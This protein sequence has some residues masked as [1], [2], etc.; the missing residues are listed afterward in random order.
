MTTGGNTRLLVYGAFLSFSI[1]AVYCNYVFVHTASV[2]EEW[3]GEYQ[4]LAIQN[5]R[6]ILDG[7]MPPPYGWRVLGDYLIWVVEQLTSID[8][9]IADQALRVL[10]LFVSCIYLFRFSLFYTSK[11]AAFC[12]V[13]IYLFLVVIGESYGYFIYN[14]NDMIFLCALH[15]CVYTL[16]VVHCYRVVGCVFL[17]TFARESTLL[18]V[19]L[20]GFLFWK[21]RK[22]LLPFMLSFFAF[23]IPFVF[24][25]WKYPA[26]LSDLA[27]WWQLL[28]NVPFIQGDMARSI[29]AIQFNVKVFLF[30]NIFWVLSI[31]YL[32]SKSDTFVKCLLYAMISYVAIIYW[33]GFIRELRLFV[34]L[35]VLILPTAMAELEQMLPGK[36]PDSRTPGASGHSRTE[37]VI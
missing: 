6:A 36:G 7:T 35:A 11:I 16:K 18:V 19:F 9:I 32:C 8:P 31:R 34:P 24:L 1:L 33:V 27:F 4:S 26:P 15:Y 37:A 14:I 30:M 17:A 21:D 3:V 25:R 29:K 28:N 10:F 23:L 22:L 12:L 2:T 5:H 13:H 20:V